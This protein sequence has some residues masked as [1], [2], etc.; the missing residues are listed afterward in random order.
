MCLRPRLFR[1][2]RPCIDD[3]GIRAEF[4]LF[5]LVV[6]QPKARAFSPLVAERLIQSC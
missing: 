2:F 4:L 6:W 5:A 1:L 3:G